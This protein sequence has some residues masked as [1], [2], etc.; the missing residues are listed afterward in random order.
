[1]L[2]T[3]QFGR[4]KQIQP[5]DYLTE[6]GFNQAKFY[7]DLNSDN[8]KLLGTEQLDWIESRILNSSAVWTIFWS[9]GLNGKIE[10]S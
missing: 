4:D 3:R 2:D 6:S 8:R 1:M 5:K 7:N 10:I 9:T